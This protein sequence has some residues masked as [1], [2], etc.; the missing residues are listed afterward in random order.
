[1]KLLGYHYQMCGR[2]ASDK[3][4]LSDRNVSRCACRCNKISDGFFLT[5]NWT[6]LLVLN[7]LCAFLLARLQKRSRITNTSKADAHCFWHFLPFFLSYTGI[8]VNA[9]QLQWSCHRIIITTANQ[10]IKRN[11]SDLH[12]CRNTI[13][14]LREKD[15]AYCYYSRWN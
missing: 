13:I 7:C 9:D 1:M 12:A 4:T 5:Y 3:V 10:R 14:S 6:S 11:K 15:R 2:Y 8:I